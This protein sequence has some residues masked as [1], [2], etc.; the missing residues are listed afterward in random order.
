MMQNPLHQIGIGLSMAQCHMHYKTNYLP[1]IHTCNTK[2]QWNR[3]RITTVKTQKKEECET[4]SR[5]L[6]IAMVESQA[7]IMNT[8]YPSS[9][10]SY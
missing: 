1:H 4:H 9:G 10:A 6:S 2:Q 5:Y 7:G 3:N 8:H